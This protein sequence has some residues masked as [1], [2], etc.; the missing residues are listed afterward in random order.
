MQFTYKT[1]ERHDIDTIII[2]WIAWTLS[3]AYSLLLT[4]QIECVEINAPRWRN[5]RVVDTFRVFRE[6]NIRYSFYVLFDLLINDSISLFLLLNN[7][8]Y[9]VVLSSNHNTFNYYSFCSM[10]STW[11]NFLYFLLYFIFLLNWSW[12]VIRN[13]TQSEFQF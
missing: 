9:F 4:K 1:S 2:E 11:L 8:K 12:F 13:Y 6:S 10:I 7:W 3:V 5:Q